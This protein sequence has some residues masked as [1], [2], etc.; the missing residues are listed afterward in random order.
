MPREIEPSF[1]ELLMQGAREAAAH[2]GGDPETRKRA[3]VTR[4]PLTA[5]HVQIRPPGPPSPSRIREIR[6]GLDVSQAVFADLLKVSPSTVRAWE[7]GKREPEGPTRRLLE[8]AER[9]PEVLSQGI[10]P[11]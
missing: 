8:I 11:L 10:R 6:E 9:A 4:R 5:R 3:R 7:Q 2:A 1:A